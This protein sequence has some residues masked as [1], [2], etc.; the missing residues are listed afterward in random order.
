MAQSSTTHDP[1]PRRS[2]DHR[3]CV[4]AALARAD[5]LCGR[6]AVRLTP[7][8]RRVLELIW[9][10]HAPVG[11]YQLMEMLAKERGPVAPPTVYRALEFLRAQGLVHRIESLNAF[12]GC[13]APAAGHHAGFLICRR[14][15]NVAEFPAAVLGDA[16]ARLAAGAGFS[17]E[18]EKI[19]VTGT[20]APCREQRAA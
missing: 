15:G 11:A 4:A 19:E 5:E 18:G 13:P 6:R 1:F 10:S 17:V 20:C 9:Q 3:S 8:R 12:I 7:L 16:L 2:H 14:C